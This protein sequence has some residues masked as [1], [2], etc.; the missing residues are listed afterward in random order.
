MEG[1]SQL[2][3]KRQYHGSPS[4]CEGGRSVVYAEGA[5]GQG[6]SHVWKLDLQSGATK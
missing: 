5:Q 4:V 2:A 1:M 3:Y 6:I